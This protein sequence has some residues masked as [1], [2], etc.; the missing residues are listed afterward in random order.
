[1]QLQMQPVVARL[2]RVVPV[3]PGVQL[4]DEERKWIEQRNALHLHAESIRTVWPVLDPWHCLQHLDIRFPS[5]PQ[6]DGGHIVLPQSRRLLPRHGDESIEPRAFP[7]ESLN[8]R[9]R[10]EAGSAEVDVL[11][12]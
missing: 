1:Q 3:M 12:V 9:L 6:L 2:L 7:L 10:R 4:A 8:H 11:A 5:I